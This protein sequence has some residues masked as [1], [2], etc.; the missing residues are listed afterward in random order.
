MFDLSGAVSWVS[1][2]AQST[3]LWGLTWV[4][5]LDSVNHW[6]CALFIAGPSASAL[7]LTLEVLPI[8]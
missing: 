6:A 3:G 8:K 2:C 5:E 7:V 1:F 4:Q